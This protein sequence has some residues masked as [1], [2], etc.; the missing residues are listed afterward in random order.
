MAEPGEPLS[1]REQDIVQ[2]VATGATNR[3]IAHQLSISPNTVKVHL[4]NIFT[5]LE[6]SSRTEATVIAIRE[7]WVEVGEG[8]D[9][10]AS[11]A[12]RPQDSL[13]HVSPPFVLPVRPLPLSRRL[14][15]VAAVALV[16]VAMIFGRPRAAAIPAATC[17]D[18]FTAECAGDAQGVVFDEPESLWVSL[19][20]MPEPR[21]R[22]ALV[23]VQN[24]LFVIGGETAGGTTGSLAIYD[25]D[26]DAWRQGAP[27][28][29][30][31][32][33]LSAVVHQGRIFAIGGRNAQGQPVD[34]VEIYDPTTDSWSEGVSLPRPLMAHSAVSVEDRVFVFGGSDGTSYTGQAWAFDPSDGRW[35]SLPSLPAPRG[36]MGAAVL[37]GLV[38]LVGGYDGQK[39]YADCDRFDPRSETFDRCPAMST[40]RGGVGAAAVAGNLFVIGGGWESF[41]A[42]SERFNPYSDVWTNVETPVL[43]AGGEWL[44]LGVISVRTRIFALGGWQQGRYLNVNQAYETLPNRLYLPA[45]AGGGQ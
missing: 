44:N 35:Q 30:P 21:G 8:E 40:P 32:A 45:T 3:Q 24:S 16:T 12:G 27:K 36:F 38:Y 31:V 19:A 1:D 17:G 15:L 43:L 2:L 37:D 29:V 9:G 23:A 6:I 13:P 10:A 26:A 25:V 4:R 20:I 42:F 34:L 28:P 7:G 39:E 5:K 33:N 22:F 14:T 41:T 18:E 11:L